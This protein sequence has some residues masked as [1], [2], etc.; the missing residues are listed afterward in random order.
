MSLA[1]VVIEDN[2]QI[3]KV[4]T[5]HS[6]GRRG[7][8]YPD[9]FYP[10]HVYHMNSLKDL[11]DWSNYLKDLPTNQLLDLI[12]TYPYPDLSLIK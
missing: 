2:N 1:V 9:G 3:I 11:N 12:L 10:I 7:Q 5:S 4:I 6:Y 8:V